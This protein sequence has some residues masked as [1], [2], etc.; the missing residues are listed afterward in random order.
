M[1]IDD[2]QGS[3]G[4][5]GEPGRAMVHSHRHKE[6]V[7]STPAE[8]YTGLIFACLQAEKSEAAEVKYEPQD[9]AIEFVI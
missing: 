9:S 7:P 1:R 6:M 8:A 3:T 4:I 5:D 2:G